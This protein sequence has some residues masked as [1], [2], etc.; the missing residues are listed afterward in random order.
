MRY[1]RVRRGSCLDHTAAAAS[2]PAS[3]TYPRSE[4]EQIVAG[5][6]GLGYTSVSPTSLPG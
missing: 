4:L 3:P 6:K 2:L 1:H 5:I